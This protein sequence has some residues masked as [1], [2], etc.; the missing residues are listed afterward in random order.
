[1][2][3]ALRTSSTN[4]PCSSC[5]AAAASTC[6]LKCFASSSSLM[7]PGFHGCTI[8]GGTS[9]A[10]AGGG[11]VL[12]VSEDRADKVPA[13]RGRDARAAPVAGRLACRESASSVVRP[14]DGHFAGITFVDPEGEVGRLQL[15]LRSASP[16]PGSSA[17]PGHR[18]S[19]PASHCEAS[20]SLVCRARAAVQ[21]TF[22]ATHSAS[23]PG[24]IAAT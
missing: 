6:F 16:S 22:C 13:D 2:G 17:L 14:L 8:C 5:T 15:A 3:L 4:T 9:P 23:S 19:V 7:S 1:M 24:V 21:R 18:G 10:R 20:F 12:L 11:G